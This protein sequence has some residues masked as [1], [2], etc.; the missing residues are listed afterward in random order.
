MVT[1]PPAAGTMTGTTPGTSLSTPGT[2]VQGVP[3]GATRTYYSYYYAPGTQPTNVATPMTPGTTAGTYMMQPGTVYY[4]PQGTIF[5]GR[6][7]APMYVAPGTTM[8]NQTYYVPTMQRRGL[9]GGLFRPRY[10]NTYYSGAP[11]GYTYVTG[12]VSY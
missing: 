10:N 6:R 2:V 1:Q 11:M 8:S 9:F 12:P 5:G 4:Y 7:F 3:P